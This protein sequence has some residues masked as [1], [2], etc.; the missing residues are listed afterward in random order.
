M[1][2]FEIIVAVPWLACTCPNLHNSGTS[3]DE[4]TGQQHL[5]ALDGVAVEIAGGLVFAGQVEGIASFPLH[6][7][8]QFHAAQ[9]ALEP[10]VWR[11]VGGVESLQLAS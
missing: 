2:S 4:A 1:I 11:Q 9:A 8:G 5:A 7:E 3:F 6:T 10:C